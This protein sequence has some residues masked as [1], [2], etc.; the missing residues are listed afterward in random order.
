MDHAFPIPG[1]FHCLHEAGLVSPEDPQVSLLTQRAF[2]RPKGGTFTENPSGRLSQVGWPLQYDL[3]LA[4]E[5]TQQLPHSHLLFVEAIQLG[6]SLLSGDV[7]SLP[8]LKR[9]EQQALGLVFCSGGLS[10]EDVLETYSTQFS[11]NPEQLKPLLTPHLDWA[12]TH[13]LAATDLMLFTNVLSATVGG[14]LSYY[15]YRGLPSPAATMAAKLIER[16][17]QHQ[18]AHVLES[19]IEKGIVLAGQPDPA[20]IRTTDMELSLYQSEKRVLVVFQKR[21]TEVA[22]W[23]TQQALPH[24]KSI[25]TLEFATFRS[26]DGCVVQAHDIV[27]SGH[28]VVLLVLGSNVGST[29]VKQECRQQAKFADNPP[30][31]VHVFTKQE[32]LDQHLQ[33]EAQGRNDGSHGWPN[34]LL[35]GSRNAEVIEAM[36]RFLAQCA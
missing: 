25:D 5:A 17:V 33:R 12:Q 3:A 22:V 8:V 36:D 13:P 1:V 18:G 20:W 29:F 27:N 11:W 34:F 31:V 28:D 26:G 7:I 35:D 15:I 14:W 30:V 32:T 19:F 2:D 16:A 23:L 4:I 21:E 10:L 9:R 24:A 6:Q